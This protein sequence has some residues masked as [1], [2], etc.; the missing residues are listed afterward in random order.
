MDLHPTEHNDMSLPA[1]IQPSVGQSLITRVSRLFNG[2]IHDVLHEL[3]QN[4]RRA[5]ASRID[6]DVT[7]IDGVQ[8]LIFSDDGSGIDDPS[9]LVTLGY[10]GWDKDIARREDP[11]GMG[12]FGLAGHHVI[13]RSWSRAAGQGWEVEIPENA[14]EGDMALAVECSSR[15]AGTQLEITLPEQWIER[16]P[17]SVREASRYFPLPV[18]FNGTELPREDFLAG[19]IRIEEC[20]GCRIGIFS[21]A[22]YDP[23]DAPRFNFHGVTAPCLMPS[24]LEIGTFDRWHVKIDI[25]DAPD[26]QLVLPARKEMVENDALATLRLEAETGIYRVIAQQSNHRLSF[27]RWKRAEQLGVTLAEAAPWLEAWMPITADS[28]GR[29]CGGPVRSATMIIVPRF[30]VDIEQGAAPILQDAARMGGEV[31][32]AEE[33]FAGYS[34]YDRLPRLDKITFSIERNGEKAV[35]GDDPLDAAFASGP[36]DSIHLDLVIA[37]STL[38]E[39][40]RN[41][42]SYPLEMLVCGNG[43]TELDEAIILFDAKAKIAPSLLAWWM[44]SCIFCASD[45]ANSDSWKTQSQFFERDARDLANALLLGEEAALIE[46]IRDAVERKVQWLH[47]KGRTLALT[48]T[49]DS[50]SVTL[51]KP[52]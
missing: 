22:G 6:I 48:A 2:T 32:C 45:D 27:K 4:S 17:D 25:V 8:K 51:D 1:S 39:A 29:E 20:R 37:E 23:N 7:D 14:W 24:V 3:L 50:L 43:G 19:A 10:S 9:A 13:I 5:G 44:K 38:P 52:A 33:Q 46:Q 35:Y 36:V 31:V 28:Q 34:W 49:R 15:T 18:I 42:L 11:A 47:P 26:L 40:R 16:L 12:V 30:D 41:H 21:A